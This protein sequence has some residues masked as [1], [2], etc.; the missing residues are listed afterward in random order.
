MS[1]RMQYAP[2][3]GL[4][5]GL[6]ERL[7][8]APLSSRSVSRFS[9]TSDNPRSV[10]RTPESSSRAW[11]RGRAA[12]HAESKACGHV[13]TD[14]PRLRRSPRELLRAGSFGCR[15]CPLH[16]RWSKGDAPPEYGARVHRVFSSI[17]VISPVNMHPASRRTGWP[18]RVR[19][20]I[21]WAGY[22]IPGHRRLLR[23]GPDHV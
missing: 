2:I 7:G 1:A 14:P 18:A 23:A 17:P 6:G 10:V 4:L 11:P 9:E 13:A 19:V 22:P 5:V 12:G 3:G 16:R 15:A 8:E 20:R 21:G